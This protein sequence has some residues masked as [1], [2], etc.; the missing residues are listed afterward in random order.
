MHR[1]SKWFGQA[2][3]LYLSYLYSLHVLSSSKT[4]PVRINQIKA[5]VTNKRIKVV[6][7]FESTSVGA[8]ILLLLALK[9]F[10]S[11]EDAASNI[12]RIRKIINPSEANHQIYKEF[13]EF[14]KRLNNQLLPLYDTHLSIREKVQSFSSETISNL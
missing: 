7:N 11:I 14:Y 10:N 9:K 13:F 6:E 5:D 2:F 12:I 1:R 8:F 3:Y 4:P